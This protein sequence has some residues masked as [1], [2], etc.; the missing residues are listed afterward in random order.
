MKNGVVMVF[1]ILSFNLKAETLKTTSE[2]KSLCGDAV[3]YF[4]KNQVKES[5]NILRPYWPLPKQ[6]LD[7][8]SSQTKTQLATVSG[9]FGNS[10]GSD[11]I[12]TQ[13]AG[14]SFIQHTYAIKFEKHALRFVCLFYKPKKDWV[15]NAVYWDDQ[16]PLFFN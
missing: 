11:F 7:T 16:T 9:R 1:L 10:V 2:T 13:E 4:S 5:F 15:V 6:E 8:L 3:E 12:K 14:S